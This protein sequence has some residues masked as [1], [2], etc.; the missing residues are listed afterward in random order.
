MDQEQHKRKSLSVDLSSAQAEIISL[1]NYKEMKEKEIA[2]LKIS[3]SA[4]RNEIISL[5]AVRSRDETQVRCCKLH[6][7]VY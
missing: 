4:V 3:L 2:D 6:L 5:N 7:Y 1:R